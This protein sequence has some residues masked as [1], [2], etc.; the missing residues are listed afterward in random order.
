[1]DQIVID[2]NVVFEGI[3][4]RGGASGLIIDAWLSGLLDVAVSAALA[5][6]YTDVL[7]RKLSV[8]RWRSAQPV[9]S[10]LLS[11]STFIDIHYRWRPAWPDR[12]DELVIDCAM[13][14]G[15]VVVTSN[16]KDFRNAV[17][18]LGLRVMTPIEL[19]QRLAE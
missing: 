2:T 10:M 16:L 13:N 5:Y 19:A 8:Q 12:G 15:A 17:D 6:E 1:M 4:R 14:A 18:H 7:M 9:L 11:Q 3:T